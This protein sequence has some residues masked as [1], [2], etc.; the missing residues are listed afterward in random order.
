MQTFFLEQMDFL[1]FFYGLSFFF[2]SFV[3]YLLHGINKKEL[4]WKFLALFA[5]LRGLYQYFVLLQMIFGVHLWLTVTLFILHLLSFAALF[6]FGRR[7]FNHDRKLLDTRVYFPLI[8][9]LC[10]IGYLT[11]LENITHTIRYV[12]GFPGAILAGIAF[13]RWSSQK[14]IKSIFIRPVAIAFW[15]YALSQL[16]MESN[17]LFKQLGIPVQLVRI[18]FSIVAF[19]GIWF[20]YQYF[21]FA[22]VFEQENVKKRFIRTRTIF[23]TVIFLFLTIMIDYVFVNQLGNY[24]LSEVNNVAEKDT[25]IIFTNLNHVI[26]EANGMASLLSLDPEIVKN[27]VEQ[28]ENGK[29]VDVVLDG[30]LKVIREGVCYL[31]NKEGTVIG[32]SNR[33]DADS[34]LGKNY[35]FRSYFTD[36]LQG[37]TGKLFALGVTSKRPGYYVS[38]PVKNSLGENLG[39]AVVKMNLDTAEKV[40]MSYKTSLLTNP[41]GVIFLSGN[42]DWKGKS[43][44]GLTESM[45]QS[46]LEKQLFGQGSFEPIFSIWPKDD[47]IVQLEQ[48]SFLVHSI[49]MTSD[50][51]ILFIFSDIKTIEYYRLFGLITTFLFYFLLILFIGISQMIRLNAVFSYFTS[52]VY[53]SQDA[54]IGKDLNG[55]IISWNFGAERIYGYTEK[56]IVGKSINTLLTKEWQEKNVILLASLR[57][58]KIIENL[59]MKHVNKNGGVIDVSVTH[60]V[61][62]DSEGSVI[63]ASVIARDVTQVKELEKTKREFVSIVSHQ[64]RTPLTGIKW[65]AELLN[66]S[67][68]GPLLKVQ[69]GYLQ[70]ISDSTQRMI[71]LVNDL[72][73]VSHIDDRDVYKMNFVNEDFSSVLKKVTD[74]QLILAKMKKIQIQLSPECLKKIVIPLDRLRFEQVLQNV[75]DN[76]IKFSSKGGIISVSCQKQATQLICSIQDHGAGIPVHQQSRVFEKFFRADNAVDSGSGTG[77]GLYI[78]KSIVEAHHGK[79]WFESE[80]NKGT[81]FFVSL[82]LKQT[83]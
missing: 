16:I 10:L 18:I 26:L 20:Q 60:S 69:R 63:G 65:F 51:W 37:K 34:F 39:V 38:A 50:G 47:L 48:K 21:L 17:P 24:A 73:E 83:E 59:E 79:I 3:S 11:G 70:Q 22:D 35:A 41:D 66:D 62:R 57:E 40:L 80:E 27:V 14:S 68:A 77:L 54:I 46:I 29:D 67:H 56:E 33:N 5:V 76:A 44:I 71:R 58:G 31:M 25:E 74:E 32:S 61:I 55:K 6:E 1:Y 72:L 7:G 15:F 9:L 81:T 36:A 28:N 45:K 53:S 75:L 78:A 30:C 2:L 64:L 12:V 19:Q 52:A 13:W 43:L 23:I 4:S 42:P 8:V 49:Q 82:P